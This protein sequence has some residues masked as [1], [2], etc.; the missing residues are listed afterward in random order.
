MEC[1]GKRRIIADHSAH[2]VVRQSRGLR[3]S[4]DS[5]REATMSRG[6]NEKTKMNLHILFLHLAISA[7]NSSP[8]GRLELS[9]RASQEQLK[10]LAS[11]RSKW[12]WIWRRRRRGRGIVRSVVLGGSLTCWLSLARHQPADGRPALEC[13]TQTNEF[14]FFVLLLLLTLRLGRAWT[15]SNLLRGSPSYFHAAAVA[16]TRANDPKQREN[17]MSD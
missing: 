9:G 11:G 5:P 6:N 8:A 16:L 12:N 1:K 17:R 3:E 14:L 13:H 4:I 2:L 7:K 15:S 10:P